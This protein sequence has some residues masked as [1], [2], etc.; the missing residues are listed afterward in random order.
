MERDSPW[1]ALSVADAHVHFFSHGFFSA[2]A[3]QKPGL[4]VDGLGGT[5]G[6]TMPAVD[7]KELASTWVHE[8]D[9]HRVARAALIASIPGDEASVTT[10]VHWHPD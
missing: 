1:G 4:E 2:L 8:L 5:L 9:R 3:S 10:A 7:P 6:W